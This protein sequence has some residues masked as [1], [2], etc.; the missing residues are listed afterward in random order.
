M[1]KKLI[2]MVGI[3]GSGK[4]TFATKL[5]MHYIKY[6]CSCEIIS[7][8]VIRFALLKDGEDYFSHED[9]VW[10]NFVNQAANSLKENEITI[11]DATHL[12]TATRKKIINAIKKKYWNK[13]ISLEAIVMD[14]CVDTCLKNNANRV[15]RAFVPESA[16]WR[17]GEQFVIP[18]EAEGFN[19]ITLICWNSEL[20]DYD[21]DMK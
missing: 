19:K 17:M 14:K 3:S 1:N 16:I 8:D 13:D 11:L 9:D 2:L 20:E 12:T 18:T 6:G 4:S 5:H 10:I 21:I 7:R 15:G